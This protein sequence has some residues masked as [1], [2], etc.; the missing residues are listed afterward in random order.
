MQ[1]QDKKIKLSFFFFFFPLNPNPNP[2]HG[3]P[4]LYFAIVARTD[5]NS[6]NHKFGFY[7]VTKARIYSV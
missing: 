1:Q 7:D 4:F 2:I 5:N 6:L 3:T